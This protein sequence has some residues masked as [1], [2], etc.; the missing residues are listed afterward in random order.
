MASN[1]TLIKVG[2][3][4]FALNGVALAQAVIVELKSRKTE[5]YVKRMEEPTIPIPLDLSA[6]ANDLLGYRVSLSGSYNH[7]SEMYLT[8]RYF[9]TEHIETAPYKEGHT[10]LNII[11][12]FF[13]NELNAGVLVNRGWIPKQLREPGTRE[14][15][16]VKGDITLVGV[17]TQPPQ[18]IK[19]TKQNNPELN[20]WD[21]IDLEEMS[22]VH[23]TQPIL[24]DCTYESSVHGGPIGGQH[25]FGVSSDPKDYFG[26]WYTYVST[27]GLVM[28]I[29]YCVFMFA[30]KRARIYIQNKTI[31]AKDFR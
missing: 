9:T 25:D 6:R 22:R 17:V 10:G 20:R 26:Y 1:R 18:V 8:P 21:Y 30:S 11:T 24:L 27:G 5:K 12:P 19:Q 7:A 14:E 28:Y 29:S 15:G 3:L 31:S 2:I 4:V 16:Q 23:N 13:C